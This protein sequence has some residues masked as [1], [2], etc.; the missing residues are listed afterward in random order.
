MQEQVRKLTGENQIMKMKNYEKDIYLENIK[1]NNVREIENIKEMHKAELKLLGDKIDNQEIV[2]N[3]VFSVLKKGETM[4][5]SRQN[6]IEVQ[7][8]YIEEK[9]EILGQCKALKETVS[10]QKEVITSQT[11]RIL[12]L[13]KTITSNEQ[14]K[15]AFEKISQNLAEKNDCDNPALVTS[16]TEGLAKQKENIDLLASSMKHN[17]KLESSYE[18]L[19]ES[20]SNLTSETD[21]YSSLISHYQTLLQNQSETITMLQGMV[22]GI[23]YQEENDLVVSGSPCKRLPLP[24][25]TG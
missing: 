19:K 21:E 1:E 3:F 4:M 16:I 18:D 12:E 15:V 23:R 5:K 11:S 10:E 25:T 20:F 6:V 24:P 22:T 8:A 7:S 13:E 9:E 2:V 17:D 14:L